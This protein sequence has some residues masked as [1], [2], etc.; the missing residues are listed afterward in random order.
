MMTPVPVSVSKTYHNT[1]T[2]PAK[3][4]APKDDPIKLIA[5]PAEEVE[6]V[7]LEPLEAVEVG[8]MVVEELFHAIVVVF[9]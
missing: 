1:A 2:A 6:V 4:A 5:P 3:A 9:V 7:I 8:T